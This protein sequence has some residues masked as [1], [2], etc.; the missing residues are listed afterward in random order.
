MRGCLI[1]N[2]T[3]TCYFYRWPFFKE[4][5]V[6]C[7]HYLIHS[8]SVTV[9]LVWACGT[10][11]SQRG[12]MFKEGLDLGSHHT[13]GWHPLLVVHKCLFQPCNTLLSM[14]IRPGL[15]SCILLSMGLWHCSDHRS[16]TDSFMWIFKSLQS[17]YLDSLPGRGAFE[18]LLG[19]ASSLSSSPPPFPSPPLPVLLPLLLLPLLLILFHHLYLF[20]LLLLLQ[21]KLLFGA[22][23]VLW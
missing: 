11:F 9:N 5:K 12:L 23:Q 10:A 1:N 20:L 15:S 7:R 17:V 2:N 16:W 6:L 18:F 8:C 22:S 4:S 19:T 21:H 13:E 14:E 3:T